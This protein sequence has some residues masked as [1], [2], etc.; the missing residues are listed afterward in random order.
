MV[1]L[2]YEGEEEITRNELLQWA[3]SELRNQQK[4]EGYV[5]LKVDQGIAHQK[6]Q[7]RG[8][9]RIP[10]RNVGREL[11][12]TQHML[13]TELPDSVG[14]RAVET[15]QINSRRETTQTYE[16]KIHAAPGG[17]IVPRYNT[18]PRECALS[19]LTLNGKFCDMASSCPPQL[20]HTHIEVHSNTQA[21]H[22]A[23]RRRAID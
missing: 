20:R 9:A 3:C 16:K 23:A 4:T 18:S 17:S 22:A 19:R 12:A 11:A 5:Q 2:K 8:Q 6:N 10:S 7:E 13:P 15:P 14:A 1:R 21:K